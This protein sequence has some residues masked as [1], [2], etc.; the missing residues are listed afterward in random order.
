MEHFNGCLICGEDLRYLPDYRDFCCF[1]CQK[2]FSSNVSCTSGHFICDSCHASSG[3]DLAEKF[4]QHATSSNPFFLATEIMRNERI[5]MHGPEHHF[6][7]PAVLIAAY[8]HATGSPEREK[9]LSIAKKRAERVPGGF[10][11][12]HGNCGAG[13]GTGIFMSIITGSTSLKTEEWN[14]SNLVTGRSLVTIAEHGG[15]RCCKRDVYLS[16]QTAVGFLKEKMG[17]V[18]ENQD[19]RCMFSDRN[20]EC[21]KAKC[22]Y[23]ASEPV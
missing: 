17:V 10:C 19:V 22:P 16:L 1:Y 4:C 7:V 21:L 20:R 18:L 8:C 13:V 3:V 14:L 12:S 6:L 2:T 11:G 9:W 23:F 5:S 15:P